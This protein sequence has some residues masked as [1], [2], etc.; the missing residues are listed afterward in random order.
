MVLFAH[1]QRDR[2]EARPSVESNP[3]ALDET[4]LD[5]E[6]D[7]YFDQMNRALRGLD[8]D[9]DAGRAQRAI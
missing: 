4:R 5:C 7:D 8:P 2:M 1:M 3:C 6:L 9:G